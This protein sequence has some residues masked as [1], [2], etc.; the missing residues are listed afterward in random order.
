[1]GL[2]SLVVMVHLSML[3]RFQPSGHGG[4]DFQGAYSKGPV[5]Q[6]GFRVP[7]W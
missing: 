6:W 1:M 5:S 4:M 3:H 2:T 7:S